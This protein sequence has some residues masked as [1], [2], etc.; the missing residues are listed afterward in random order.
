VEEAEEW[1]RY[2]AIIAD[3]EWETVL[4]FATDKLGATGIHDPEVI[5]AWAIA[6]WVTYQATEK[7]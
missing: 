4:Y 1:G 3:W 5:T 6:A 7:E 2:L